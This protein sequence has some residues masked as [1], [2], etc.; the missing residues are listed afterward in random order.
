MLGEVPDDAEGDSALETLV[1]PR[2]R[3]IAARHVIVEL[4]AKT[5]QTR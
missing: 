4:R 3:V 5:R 1:R 2:A